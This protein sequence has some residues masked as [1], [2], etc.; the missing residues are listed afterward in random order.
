MRGREDGGSGA[1]AH[2]QAGDSLSDVEEAPPLIDR[3][4]DDEDIGLEGRCDWVVRQ[5]DAAHHALLPAEHHGACDGGPSPPG[6]TPWEAPANTAQHA[7]QCA[8]LHLHVWW[9]GP[10]NKVMHEQVYEADPAQTHMTSPLGG[11][12]AI[13]V[14]ICFVKCVQYLCMPCCL[15]G[16]TKPHWTPHWP[17]VSSQSK[18][19]EAEMTRRP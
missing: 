19:T 13:P 6:P 18:T 2:L 9:T 7:A 10:D 5:V 17:R 15:I 4:V 16:H 1:N 12:A 11:L 8:C 14:W 3:P